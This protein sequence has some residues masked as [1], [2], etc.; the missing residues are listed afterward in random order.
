MPHHCNNPLCRLCHP[1]RHWWATQGA[2][3]IVVGVLVAGVILL[4]LSAKKAKG[5]VAYLHG[6]LAISEGMVRELEAD[7]ELLSAQV[8][9]LMLEVDR[10]EHLPPVIK[11]EYRDRYRVCRV[12]PVFA[13]ESR[14]S[15]VSR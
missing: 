10:L 15:G 8:D 7:K 11:V 2:T 12:V 6:R 13:R 4:H 3:A 5:E 9:K 14:F 1:T